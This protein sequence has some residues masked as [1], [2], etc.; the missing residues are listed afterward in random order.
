MILFG[1][2]RERHF[3][4][5]WIQAGRFAGTDK[6]HILDRAE[7]RSFPALGVEES[8]AFVQKH[9]W[10]GAAIGAVRR[11]DRWSV[12]PEAVREAVINAVVHTDYAQRG[13]PI[14]RRSRRRVGEDSTD[15]S[16]AARSLRR[17]YS[18]ASVDASSA[19]E[20]R[21]FRNNIRRTAS[22]RSWYL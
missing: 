9:A 5:A 20:R 15:P 10:Q 21:P 3:P 11:M 8:V 6:S 1:R 13:A 4:D 19:S 7:I 16:S 14:R 2:E 22:P 17:L 18:Q 12:P